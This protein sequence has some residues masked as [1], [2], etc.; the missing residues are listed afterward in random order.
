MGDKVTTSDG[1]RIAELDLKPNELATQVTEIAPLI[2]KDT[3]SIIQ[4][5]IEPSKESGAAIFCNLSISPFRSGGM[6]SEEYEYKFNLREDKL[7]IQALCYRIV[8][9]RVNTDLKNVATTFVDWFSEHLSFMFFLKV[10]GYTAERIFLNRRKLDIQPFHY[11]FN[12]PNAPSSERIIWPEGK[13]K[14][15]ELDTNDRF[16]LKLIDKAVECAKCANPQIRPVRVNGENMYVLYLHP[17]QVIQLQANAGQ[18]QWRLIQ[19]S[20]FYGSRSQNPL[21]QGSLGVYNNVILR[22]SEYVTPG[23][24]STDNTPLENVRRAVLL[25]AQSAILA[26][27]KKGRIKFSEADFKQSINAIAYTLMDMKK[28]RFQLSEDSEEQDFATIVIPTYSG[29]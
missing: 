16:H 19:E 2:G 26:F 5:I 11:G 13:T 14:E 3:N 10:C 27:G 17:T 8:N 22:E 20:T 12:P 21:F 24:H 7:N 9:I 15:E 4:L 6:F 28:A 18:E 23:V 25:G 1:P 29:E